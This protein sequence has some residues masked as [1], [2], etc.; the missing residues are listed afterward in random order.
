MSELQELQKSIAEE[1]KALNDRIDCA[2]KPPNILLN[3]I[4]GNYLS[5]RGKQVRPIVVMLS[6]KIASGHVNAKAIEGGAAVELLHNASLIHDDV[7]DDSKERRGRKTVNALWDNH[8][9]VLV[10]DYFTTTALNCAI[11]TNELKIIDSICRLG[12]KLSL[13]ELDQIHN[14]RCNLLSE[15]AYMQVIERKTASLFVACAEIGCNAVGASEDTIKKLS[16]FALLLGL[17]FQIRDD[18]FDYFTSDGNTVGKPTGNDLREGKVTLP[19]I[20]VLLQKALPDNDKMLKLCSADQLSEP[21]IETLIEYEKNNGGIDYA[22]EK[23]K[24]LQNAAEKILDTFPESA[25]REQMRHL[26]SYVVT[27]SY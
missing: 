27:R 22:R 14:A 2:L 17:C 24:E 19:L 7:V 25:A 8:I 20:H 18:I 1:L 6:A 9:A 26:L 5:V 21:E 10:G 16:D 15:E 12:Q 11:G 23:M 13:G 4:I 3:S